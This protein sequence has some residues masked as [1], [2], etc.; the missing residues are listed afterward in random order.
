MFYR[1]GLRFSHKRMMFTMRVVGLFKE[2][3]GCEGFEKMMEYEGFGE[4]EDKKQW[5]ENVKGTGEA[6]NETARLACLG[7]GG[8]SVLRKLG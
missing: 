6:R 3:G 1:G 4:V 2:D 7:R 8:V 5:G